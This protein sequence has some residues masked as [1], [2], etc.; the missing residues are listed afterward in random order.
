MFLQQ[1]ISGITIGSTYALVA[2]GYSMVF[3]VMGLINFANGNIYML[4][5]F[6]TLELYMAMRGHFVLAVIL[7]IVLTGLLGYGI[8]C[9][10]LK[11]LRNRKSPKMTGILF[12]LGISMVIEDSVRLFFSQ[13][14]LPFPNMI[15][16]GSFTIG[17]STISW[18][19]IIILGCA[20]LVMILTSLLVYKTKLGRAMLAV[21]QNT[22]AAMLM[23]IDS[24]RVIAFTYAIS[25]AIATISG[26]LVGMYYQTIDSTVGATVNMKALASSVLGGV[27]VLPGAMVGGIIIGILEALGASY[28]SSAYRNAI[29]FIVLIIVILVKPAGLFGKKQIE[30]V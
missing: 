12:T 26:V 7:A 16:F 24:D 10:G 14:T 9:F 4:G 2:I 11:R 27:G 18:S 8:D 23:G 30:K 19:Q 5:G 28:I 22:E 25:A 13:E 1:L 3:G 6:I 15:D 21:S 17:S 20:A 29:A